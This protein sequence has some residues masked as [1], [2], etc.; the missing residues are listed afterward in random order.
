MTIFCDIPEQAEII[1][2]QE[3]WGDQDQDNSQLELP[4]YQMHMTQKGRGKGIATYFKTGFQVTGTI[5]APQYQISRVSCK[6]YDLINVYRS[7]GAKTTEFIKDLGSLARGAKPCIIVGDFNANY[8]QEPKHPIIT[9]ITSCAF[10]QLV[11]SP[12]HKEGGLIDHVYSKRIPIQM[13]VHFSW[14]FYTDH[15]AIFIEKS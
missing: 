3:I 2:L 11:Q 9:K 8:L 6:D 5:A 15:A 14:P 1:A 13:H 12:T 10:S 7:Q 4:G